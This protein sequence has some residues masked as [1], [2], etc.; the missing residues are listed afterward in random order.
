MTAA[1]VQDFL[2]RKCGLKGL[3]G[4]SK[5]VRELQSS[6]DSRASLA[7]DYFCYRVARAEVL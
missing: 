5:D 1:A 6:R 2:Y 4:I 3:S 7:L